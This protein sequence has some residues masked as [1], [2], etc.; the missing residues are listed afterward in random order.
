MTVRTNR[1]VFK[2]V[3][4]TV[5]TNGRVFKLVKVTVRTNRRVFK[6]GLAVTDKTARRAPSNKQ[7]E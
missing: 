5:R 7:I 4:V 1:R 6:L 2:L 3:K